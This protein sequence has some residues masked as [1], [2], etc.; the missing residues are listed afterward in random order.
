MPRWPIASLSV[1]A[2]PA[3]RAKPAASASASN[4]DTERGMTPPDHM[5]VDHLMGGNPAPSTVGNEGT[6]VLPAADCVKD[7]WDAPAR[8][9]VD[10]PQVI[11][12]G[13]QDTDDQPGPDQPARNRPARP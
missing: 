2:A 12:R 9:P 7:G 5:S 3:G 1:S 6:R 13:S 11:K 4:T 10:H 8:L